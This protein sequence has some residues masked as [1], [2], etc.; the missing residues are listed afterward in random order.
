MEF[1]NENT[2]KIIHPAKNEGKIGAVIL[3]SGDSRR[4]ASGQ[5][6]LAD[7]HGRPLVEYVFKTALTPWIDTRI[8]VT[9]WQEVRNICRALEIPCLFHDKPLLSDTIRLGL[10]HLAGIPEQIFSENTQRTF[11]KNAQR[12]F[13]ENAHG[14]SSGNMQFLSNAPDACIFLQGDQPLLR[15]ESIKAL[16]LAFRQD[17]RFC[18]RLSYG[19]TA[20][21]PILF[22]KRFFPE[23]LCLPPD[24]G[25]GYVIRK[26]PDLV[27][28][29]EARH[30]AELLDADTEEALHQL[31]TLNQPFQEV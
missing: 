31:S 24:C 22:P 17:Q 10:S 11:S 13:L 14:T 23:L 15:S 12:T 2:E 21:S 18:Y 4:F 19:N 27:K 1:S 20:G 3:A 25:G 29:V 26:Y 6:L 9:R 5:K 28:T 16:V 8:A 30:P 7:F